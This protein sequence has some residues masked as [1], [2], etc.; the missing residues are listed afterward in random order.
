MLKNEMR[1][2]TVIM[3]GF[4]GIFFVITAAIGAAI[5]PPKISPTIICQF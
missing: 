3:N 2:P 4:I 1:S 5:T